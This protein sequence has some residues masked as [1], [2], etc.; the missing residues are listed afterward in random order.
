MTRT[1]L[2]MALGIGGCLFATEAAA[3]EPMSCFQRFAQPSALVGGAARATTMP[4]TLATTFHPAPGCVY[5]LSPDL[6]RMVP[7]ADAE[8]DFAELAEQLARGAALD[9]APHTIYARARTGTGGVESVFRE[10]CTDVL[11][12]DRIAFEARVDTSTRLLHVRRRAATE[13]TLRAA[14]LSDCGA[15]RLV[16][17]FVAV[18]DGQEP[19]YLT[20]VPDDAEHD[21]AL[22][23]SEVIL[24]APGRFAV[25]ATRPSVPGNPRPAML[26]GRLALDSPLT[27]LRRA[28]STPAVAD[29]PW[30]RAEWRD[31]RMV[32]ARA[33]GS[34]SAALWHEVVLAAASEQLWLTDIPS[35]PQDLHPRVHGRLGVTSGR[36][37]FVLPNGMVDAAMRARFGRAGAVMT[38][39][40]QEWESLRRGLQ[41][42]VAERYAS[43]GPTASPSQLPADTRC[44]RL[45]NV[46]PAVTLAAAQAATTP[47]PAPAT[48]LCLRR[49]QW[50]LSARGMT[51]ERDLPSA[52]LALDGSAPGGVSL[53]SVGDRAALSGSPAGLFLCIE[54]H[55]RPFAADPEGR[56]VRVWR[57]GLAELRRASTP[58]GATSRE[59]LTLARF[60]VVDPLTDLHPVGLASGAAVPTTTVTPEEDADRAD[61]LR[62]G[63]W[64]TVAHDE[65]DVFAYV[66][67]RNAMRFYFTST[68]AV[69]ALW[70]AADRETVLTTQL[71]VVG[72]VQRTEVS[73]PPS[74]LVVL[75]TRDATCPTEPSTGVRARA[76]F[77]PD[78]R[79]VD[80]T[81]HA[82]LARDLG[83]DAPFE[84]LAHAAFRVREARALAPTSWLH[85]GVLGDAQAA[86][87]LADPVSFGVMYPLGFAHAR[88][89]V[90]FHVEGAV[91]VTASVNFSDGELSRAGAGVSLAL[92]WGPLGL[93]PRLI[94]VGA[95]L[96]LA[97]GSAQ[98]N[99][100]VSPYVGLNL[101]TLVDAL[102]GR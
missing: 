6:A 9:A 62:A 24:G 39:T 54:N 85:L 83:G 1:T 5:G 80:Q 27:E 33:A 99:P 16:L 71:P 20:R 7:V 44:A 14:N 75:L 102:G 48:Q 19:A 37:G 35:S 70:N 36:D 59:A 74:G 101:N 52:C 79:L 60:V 77:D 32:F 63:P 13:S 43:A 90:G 87:F 50:R 86:F 95:M 51:P 73:P 93:V 3:V 82:W 98:N 45:A 28:M 12:S 91:S 42:C 65:V 55:C 41:V 17:R 81:V 4:V 47:A 23:R 31:D 8:L 61:E 30:F 25:Y 88:L 53:A 67:R 21:L 49:K 2:A 15:P 22:D 68:A 96:H 40:L 56:G 58:E 11:F 26:V 100:W 64:S 92:G 78:A 69:S 38:P 34:E 18:P 29:Q 89:P 84:C 76:P 97:T 66:R 57:A 72:G 94:T 10:S 46:S